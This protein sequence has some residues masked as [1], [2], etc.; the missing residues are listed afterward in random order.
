MRRVGNSKYKTSEYVTVLIYLLGLSSDG[1]EKVLVYIR[2]ELYL[3]NDLR[4]K[5][6]ISNDILGPK[7]VVINIIERNVYISSC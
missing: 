1:E 6:L 7:K 3:V 5:I 4:A 2:R